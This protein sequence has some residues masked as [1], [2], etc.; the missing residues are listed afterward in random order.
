MCLYPRLI[1]NPKYKKNKKNGGQV[2]PVFDMRQTLVPIG[3]QKCKECR[4][5]KANGW[6]VRLMEDIKTNTNGVFVTLTMSDESYAKLMHEVLK[7]SKP[8]AYD[9][10]NAIAKKG[11]RLFLE[12]WRK[13][14]KT[15]IR[16][17]L[18]T[19][20]GHKGTEN[21]HIHGI[22]W[23][24]NKT[25]IAKIWG[26]GFVYL[27]KWVN[28]KTVNYM[29]KYV[30]K[31]DPQHKHYIPIILTTAGIGNNYTKREEAKS[32]KYKEEETKETYRLR[33]GANIAMPNYYRNKIYTEREREELW[34]YKLN[35]QERWING[36]RIDISN[37]EEEYNE[38]LKYAQEENKRL[39]YGGINETWEEEQYERERRMIKQQERIINKKKK[40]KNNK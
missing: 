18:I 1:Q 36:I 26:Y 8:T 33:N 6:K 40:K 15:S 24:D 16:H 27:G 20:L 19:E 5:Q 23:T 7:D 22:I 29:V 2:P 4:K 11:T 28:E 37:G 3:C 25:E 30:N 17:W 10:D 14:Y 12:R 21:I 32:N 9:L 38:A 13:K 31:V 35:K 34:L 39:G